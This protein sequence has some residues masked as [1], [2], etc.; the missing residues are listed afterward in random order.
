[1]PEKA[2]LSKKWELNQVWEDSEALLADA[3]SHMPEMTQKNPAGYYMSKTMNDKCYIQV[4]WVTV[5]PRSEAQA[6]GWLQSIIT[7]THVMLR[8]FFI[9]KCTWYHS[10]MVH[11]YTVY[12]FGHHPHP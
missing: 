3:Q 2:S 5:S 4:T 1:M 6:S 12:L 8:L 10:L 11:S 7:K 9:V